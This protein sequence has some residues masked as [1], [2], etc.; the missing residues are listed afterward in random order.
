MRPIFPPRFCLQQ[1]CKPIYSMYSEDFAIF[2]KYY[3]MSN[4]HAALERGGVSGGKLKYYFQ[5]GNNELEEII[6]FE[7]FKLNT[8]FKKKVINI[9][10]LFEAMNHLLENWRFF[11]KQENDQ[12]A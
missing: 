7:G 6:P 1:N 2:G 3:L 4:I 9:L 10:F 11:F 8:S 12:A 5:K